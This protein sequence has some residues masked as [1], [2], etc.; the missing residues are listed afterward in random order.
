[1]PSLLRAS[2][3]LAFLCALSACA[4]SGEHAGPDTKQLVIYGV[5]TE[6]FQ[7]GDFDFG[8]EWG[9]AYS[10]EDDRL[11]RQNVTGDSGEFALRVFST[12]IGHDQSRFRAFPGRDRN[13]IRHRF[14]DSAALAV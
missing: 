8:A 13:R 14:C 4:V 12:L 11:I 3:L 10:G 7:T 9:V 1:M 6:I 5:V 2:A